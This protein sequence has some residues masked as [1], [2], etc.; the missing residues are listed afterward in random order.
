MLD[1]QSGAL[2]VT[3]SCARERVRRVLTRSVC[4]APC[5]RPRSETPSA[6]WRRLPILLRRQRFERARRCFGASAYVMMAG[7]STLS[8]ASSGVEPP[9]QS[10]ARRAM[11]WLVRL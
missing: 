1:E 4:L 2:P 8:I 9:P 3:D 10:K 11:R 5:R 6:T 7:R